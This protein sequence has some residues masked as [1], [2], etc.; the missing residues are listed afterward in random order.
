MFGYKKLIV[1]QKA[2]DLVE[3]VYALIKILPVEERYALAEQMRRS[4]IS[5]P[6]NIAEGAGRAADKEYAHFLAIARGSLYELLSQLEAA[7]RLGYLTIGEDI[8]T[9]AREIARM[10]G[11]MLRKYGTIYSTTTHYN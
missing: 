2:M 1:W 7:E 4:V 9:L 6:S 10:L 8:E 5:V 11:A 3:K